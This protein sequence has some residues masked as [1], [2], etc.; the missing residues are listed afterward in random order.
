[1][2]CNAFPLKP[3]FYLQGLFSRARPRRLVGLLH[4]STPF[5][6]AVTLWAPRLKAEENAALAH[7]P[8][9][10]RLRVVAPSAV[11]LARQLHPS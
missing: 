8:C 4:N 5:L 6:C 9:V 7:T 3:F 2:L 1:M 11:G 10:E